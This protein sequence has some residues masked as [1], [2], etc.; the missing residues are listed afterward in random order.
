MNR[1]MEHVDAQ[2][3]EA[4]A[5]VLQLYLIQAG[6]AK[7][8]EPVGITCVARPKQLQVPYR[9]RQNPQAQPL[10]SPVSHFGLG[11]LPSRVHDQR[12]VFNAYFLKKQRGLPA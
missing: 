7:V 3:H 2:Q 9:A 6:A 10:P 1:L 12:A 8:P 5:L 11:S 4:F